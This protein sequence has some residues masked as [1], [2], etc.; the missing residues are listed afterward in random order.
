MKTVVVVMHLCLGGNLDL[1]TCMFFG[2]GV[3]YSFFLLQKKSEEEEQK[4]KR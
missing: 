3:D 1:C 2:I 4:K